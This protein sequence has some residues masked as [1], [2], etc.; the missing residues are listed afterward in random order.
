MGT[1]KKSAFKIAALAAAALV[2]L[3]ATGC[4]T[5]EENYRR[6]YEAAKQKQIEEAGGETIYNQIRREA[7]QE[8][9]TSNGDTIRYTT[10]FVLVTK[11]LGATPSSLKRY[12]LVAGQFKQLFHAKSLMNRLREAGY[13]ESFIVQT[14]EPYYYVVAASSNSVSEIVPLMK[15]FETAPPVK[16]VEPC[17]WILRPTNR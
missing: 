11:D 16:L 12:N 9:T 8:A 4:R 1:K 14:R 17:P 15:E 6:A 13:A 7:R 2:I 10:Q 3:A 5:N